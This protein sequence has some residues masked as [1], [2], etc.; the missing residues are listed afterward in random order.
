M[1]IARVFKSGNSQAVRLPKKFRV[2]SSE[3]EIFR[4]A[5]WSACW[6]CWPS[7]QQTCFQGSARTRNHS[8][9]R[10]YDERP[11]Y[12]RH[13][14][15]HLFA[16]EP[17]SRSDCA[18][19]PNAAWRCRYIGGYLWRVALWRGAKPATQPC[20]GVSRAACISF[21]CG[22]LGGG[23]CAGLRRDPRGAG[24]PRREDRRQRSLDCCSRQ[25]RWA[26]SR[27]QQ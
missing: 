14:Y 17:A 9:A 26:H 16:A 12:A 23:S 5:E 13:Q 25:I 27:H 8:A 18:I 21:A 19:P 7:C 6:T 24:G 4:R 3:V 20:A 15:L 10:V 11:L 22:S 2:K 1:A